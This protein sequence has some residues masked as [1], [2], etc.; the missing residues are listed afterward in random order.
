MPDEVGPQLVDDLLAL[1]TREQQTE[2]LRDVGLLNASGLDRL[3]D[4][5]DELLG[6]DPDKARRLTTLCIKL[7][8]AVNAPAAMPR[9]NYV[10]AG[11]HEIEGNFDEAIRLSETA[12]SGYVTLGMNFEALRTDAGLMSALIYAG[13][14]REALATGQTIL[15]NLD[16]AGGLHVSPTPTQ[17]KL[18]S[19]LVYQN[20]GVCYDYTGRYDEALDAYSVAEQRFRA[21]NMK[22]RLGG[23]LSNRGDI[24]LYLGRSSEALEAHETAASIFHEAGLAL[25]QA[26]ALGNIGK[27]HLQ[28]G[29]YSRSLDA[30]ER[31]RRLLD[32]LDALAMQQLLLLNMADAY[33]ALGLYRDALTTYREADGSLQNAGMTHSRAEALWGMGSTLIISSEF[34]EAEQVLSEAAALFAAA[35]NVPMLSGVTLERAALLAVR[36]DRASSIEMARHAQDLVSGGEWPVQLVYTHLRLADLLLPDT[37]EAERYLLAAQRL[38]APLALPQLRYRLNERLGHLRRLQNRDEEARELLETAVDEI[39]RLRGT[40]AQDALRVSFLRDRTAAYD[41]LLRLHLAR[42]DEESVHRA[43]VVAE[44][45]KSRALVDLLTGVS[46]REF[47]PSGD[48]ELEKRLQTLQADLNATY[49]DLLGGS[50]GDQRDTPMPDLRARAVELEQEISRLRLQTAALDTTSDPFAASVALGTLQGRLPVDSIL[51][52]YHVVGDEIIAFV[53]AKD[54]VEVARGLSTVAKVGRLLQKLDVQWGRFRAGQRFT[55]RHKALLERST[56]QVL[57]ALYNELVTPLEPL[58]QSAIARVAG[59]ADSI[60]KLAIVPHGPLHLIPLHALYDGDE[61]LIERFEVSYAPSA[62]VYSLCQESDTRSRGE[63]AVF[64][65]ED[66]SIPAALA[67]ARVVAEH[68]PGAKVY[69]GEDATVE[70]LREGASRGG[71]L[72]LACH[73]LFRSDNPMFSALKLHDGWLT[74][75]EAMSLNLSET[76]VTLSACESG[77]SEVVGGDEVLGLTRAFLGAG[78]TTLA[79]SLWL[80]QDDTTAEL[81]GGWYKRLRD[82]DSRAAALRDV[83]LEIKEKYPHPYFW[84]PFILIGKR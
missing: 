59:E 17:Y 58:L 65:V 44:R 68:I 60:P 18:L 24:L 72:H 22:E 81:M 9:A 71:T 69:V 53:G 35:G 57:A 6:D 27:A 2:F 1:E 80:V 66:P 70:T 84:A 82:G 3:L 19:G 4:V 14:Y 48:P 34:E 23:I 11:V 63:A 8:D 64:G 43:F 56:R 38:A 5:A 52:A 73:G 39:E 15:D 45:A 42:D 21:L 77:R 49:N 20:R 13:R 7:I 41:G 40:V 26:K 78:A 74:A 36:G 75:A 29:N 33:L 55:E 12:H 61:Y 67:E 10:L 31:A 62:T 37:T 83:Q 54:R 79:V 47:G 50:V 30:N 25:S 76:L 32:S 51:L 16:G 28:S 46:E